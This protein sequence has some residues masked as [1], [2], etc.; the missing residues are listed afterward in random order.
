ML[1]ELKDAKD[2]IA[3][4]GD[5]QHNSMGRNAKYGAYSVYSFSE[6]KLIHFE[7]IQVCT[8][9]LTISRTF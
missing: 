3:L 5:A 6:A 4:G 2:S 8:L 9:P 1:E 7:L